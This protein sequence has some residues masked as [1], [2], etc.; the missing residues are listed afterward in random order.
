MKD[1]NAGG[2]NLGKTSN[3]QFNSL[4]SMQEKT[5]TVTNLTEYG[6]NIPLDTKDSVIIK[7]QTNEYLD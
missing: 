1:R 6:K 4:R 2:L 3:K 7:K 5:V